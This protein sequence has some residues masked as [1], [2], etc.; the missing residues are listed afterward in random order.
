VALGNYWV[1]NVLVGRRRV[2]WRFRAQ[3]NGVFRAFK[4]TINDSKK[5]LHL[6]I[7]ERGTSLQVECE[8]L[9]DDAWTGP[10]KLFPH[11]APLGNPFYDQSFETRL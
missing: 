11:Y 8:A 3:P 1:D 6:P 2:A 4:E 10:Y 7:E 5:A 9:T